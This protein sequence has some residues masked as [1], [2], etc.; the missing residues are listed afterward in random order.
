[1]N[2]G[3]GFP[4]FLAVPCVPSPLQPPRLFFDN[5]GPPSAARDANGHWAHGRATDPPTY[6]VRAA[7]PS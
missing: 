3:E 2:G 5:A 6:G 7:P 1:M 4:G